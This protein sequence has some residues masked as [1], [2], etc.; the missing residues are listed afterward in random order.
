MKPSGALITFEGLDGCGKT[1][2]LELEAERLRRLSHAVIATKEPGGTSAGRRIRDIVL[3]GANGPLSPAAE[4]ALMF[5]A[6]AQHLEEVIRPAI[7][8]GRVVLCDRFTDSTI[9]YQGYG[10]G[11]A[12]EQIEALDKILCHGLRPDLTLLLDI[13]P[14]AAALRTAKRNRASHVPNTR[15]EEEGLEFFQR[16]RQGYMAIAKREP[17]RVRIIE[18]SRSIPE[19]EQSIAEFVDQ[20]LKTSRA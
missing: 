14:E 13:T 20:F 19:V 2:Q 16:V 12:L 17:E 18:A 3:N 10:R 15:F 5:A 11:V 9:A 7:R 4:L 8:A 6:R 1:S